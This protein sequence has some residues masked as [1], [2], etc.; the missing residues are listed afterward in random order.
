MSNEKIPSLL[1]RTYPNY[2]FV[3]TEP[4]RSYSEEERQ[5]TSPA[6][7]DNKEEEN[8]QI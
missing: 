4:I 6:I 5:P 3:I 8:Y 1:A 2:R 7:K